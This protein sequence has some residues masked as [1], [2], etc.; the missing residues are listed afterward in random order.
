MVFLAQKTVLHK[1]RTAN[2]G[3]PLSCVFKCYFGK[4]TSELWWNQTAFKDLSCALLVPDGT[5]LFC[6]TGNGWRDRTPETPSV[7]KDEVMQVIFQM[8][9]KT[10]AL[11][12]TGRFQKIHFSQ[13]NT[14]KWQ[15]T[16]S[17]LKEGWKRWGRQRWRLDRWQVPNLSLPIKLFWAVLHALTLLWCRFNSQLSMLTALSYISYLGHYVNELQRLK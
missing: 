17:K 2:F 5:F 15:D 16:G 13:F 11:S 9:S 10:L 8:L 4:A 6:I 12:P 14:F 3:S 1:T 7:L